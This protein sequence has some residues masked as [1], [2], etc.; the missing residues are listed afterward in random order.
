MYSVLLRD[1]NGAYYQ[2]VVSS[3]QVCSLGVEPESIVAEQDNL[4]V[5]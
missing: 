1:E 3:S 2:L 4:F 5:H